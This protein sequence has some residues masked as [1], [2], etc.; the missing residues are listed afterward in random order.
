MW[1]KPVPQNYASFLKGLRLKLKC[2]KFHIS[3][4]KG[5]WTCSLLNQF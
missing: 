4:G 2:K 5:V 3:R 1:E